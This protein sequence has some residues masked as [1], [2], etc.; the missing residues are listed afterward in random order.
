MLSQTP[1]IPVVKV[2]KSCSMTCLARFSRRLVNFGPPGERSK[3]GTTT[4]LEPAF[5]VSS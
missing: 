3:D 4:T 2:F 5:P 1:K